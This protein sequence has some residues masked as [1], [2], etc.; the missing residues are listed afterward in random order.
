MTNIIEKAESVID[1]CRTHEQ[2]A[3]AKRYAER[4]ASITG[5]ALDRM[6]LNAAVVLK[7]A[8]LDRPV[9]SFVPL[10]KLREYATC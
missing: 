8:H 9:Y 7:E 4:A 2:L 3:A 6:L 10:H 1:S 5:C